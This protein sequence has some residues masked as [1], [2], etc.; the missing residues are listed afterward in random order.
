MRFNKR[1]D[2]TGHLFQN[3]F[4]ARVVE[5]DGHARAVCRYVVDNPVRARLC[6]ERRHWP[7]WGLSAL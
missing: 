3:R 4:D 6:K 5:G 2:R 7:W 1:Y